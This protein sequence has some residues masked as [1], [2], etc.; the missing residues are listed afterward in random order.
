MYQNQVSDPGFQ[1]HGKL[2]SI[3]RNWYLND[4]I[5]LNRRTLV[6]CCAECSEPYENDCEP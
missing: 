6:D 2:L 5:N 4:D 3:S 1:G